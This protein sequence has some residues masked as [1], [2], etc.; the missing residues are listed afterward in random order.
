MESALRSST[1]TCSSATSPS[2]SMPRATPRPSTPSPSRVSRSTPSSSRRSWP[3][4]PR[5]CAP[6]LPPPARSSLTSSTPPTC[7]P[8]SGSW[9]RSTTTSSW[10]RRLTS[11]S[12]TWRPS[13]WPIRSSSSPASTS[14]PSRT[15][16]SPSSCS[17]PWEST[18]T[19]SAWSSIRPEPRSASSAQRSRRASGSGCS[20]CS[21]SS[22]GWMT[23]STTGS[24]SSP[25]SRRPSS[26]S[27]SA[28]SWITSRGATMTLRRRS[29]SGPEP[30]STAGDSHSGAAEEHA[31]IRVLLADESAR[32][33]E[34]LSKRL[35]QEEDL[36][37]CAVAGD[38][39]TALQEALRT[40][41]EVA[42][43]D[44]GLPGMDGIQTTEMLVQ[45]LPNTG[46]ILLS[47]EAENEAFRR[48]MLAGAREFLQ[49]PFS[50]DEL[51]AAIRRVHA[52]G[53]RKG[54][55]ASSPAAGASAGAGAAPAPGGKLFTV[56][57]AKGGVGKSAIAAN[58]AVSLC[59]NC[60]VALLDCSLQFGDIGILLDISSE[61]T[62]ADLAANNAVAD[63]DVVEEVMVDGPGGVRVLAAPVRPEL[64]DYVTTQHLRAL[65]E[66]LRRTYDRIVVDTATHLS[67]IS[68]DLVEMADKVLV[69]TDLSTTGV[70][71]ARLLQTVMG[72]LKV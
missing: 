24:R 29:R 59:R 13:R 28:C 58:L 15:P 25:S 16:R 70:K 56:V 71:N 60:R 65:M 31:M 21:R 27:N 4:G 22:L 61:R 53:L 64:A 1:S 39:D 44:A 50:G 36:T 12:A 63:H 48:A 9:P 6:C 8:S 20:R 69:V 19:R 14:R 17:S 33:I 52:Y 26:A 23:S 18:G 2:C 49:K 62:I 40:Q 68:L 67:E 57:G 35:G 51:V 66:Q 46:V 34:N 3:R 72:V 32:I 55:P 37:V 11:K 38:G 30:G 41:P 43:V 54:T 7:V 47:M 42:V 45:Y 10:I 5:G